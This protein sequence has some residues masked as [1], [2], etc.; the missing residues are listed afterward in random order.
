ML[1]YRASDDSAMVELELDEKLEKA[2]KEDGVD[3]SVIRDELKSLDDGLL[4]HAKPT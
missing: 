4:N 2:L 1:L 3:P